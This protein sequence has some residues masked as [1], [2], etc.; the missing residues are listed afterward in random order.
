MD[1]VAEGIETRL[2][3]QVAFE[4]GCDGVQGN[5]YAPAMPAHEFAD[6]FRGHSVAAA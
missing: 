6:Y 5:F 2:Q 3:E 4:A 1:V